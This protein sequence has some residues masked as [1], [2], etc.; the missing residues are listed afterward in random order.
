MK[1]LFK[2]TSRY[3]FPGKKD[4]MVM[5]WKAAALNYSTAA[6]FA[7]TAKCL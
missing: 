2:E 1:F 4:F 6:A 3:F 5:P 7:A